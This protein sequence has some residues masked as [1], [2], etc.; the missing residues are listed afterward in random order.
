MLDCRRGTWLPSSSALNSAYFFSITDEGSS[1][2]ARKAVYIT[3]KGR[4]CWA[5]NYSTVLG[6]WT[7]HVDLNRIYA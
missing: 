5:L 6:Y 1:K 2:F 7:S 3:G 4:I